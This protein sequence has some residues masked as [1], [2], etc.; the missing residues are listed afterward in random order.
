MCVLK[1]SGLGPGDIF[2]KIIHL[3]WPCSEEFLE[4][5][6]ARAPQNEHKSFGTWENYLEILKNLDFAD[7][8]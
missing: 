6:L 4:T 2:A 8:L 1:C 5:K 7:K 3:R